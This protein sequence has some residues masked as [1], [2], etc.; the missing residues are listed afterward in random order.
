LVFKPAGRPLNMLGQV[1]LGRDELEALVLCDRDGLTQEQA[2]ESMG[3]SRGTVQR[4][5]S[6]ARRKI[7]DALARERALVVRGDSGGGCVRPPRDEGPVQNPA[8]H[9]GAESGSA[10]VRPPT[11]STDSARR[12]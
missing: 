7:A 1:V 9:C 5:V 6:G 10:G 2:G 12:A 3:V 4:L 8:P 11:A